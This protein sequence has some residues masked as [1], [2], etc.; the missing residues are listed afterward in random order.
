MLVVLHLNLNWYLLIK[1]KNYFCLKHKKCHF[2]FGAQII[3]VPNWGYVR[4]NKIVCLHRNLFRRSR[5]KYCTKVLQSA[6]IPRLSVISSEYQWRYGATGT[7]GR[8]YSGARYV[9]L[10][11]L[12][13]INQST[14]LFQVCHRKCRVLHRR[15]AVF[16]TRCRLATVAEVVEAAEEVDS[17]TRMPPI[18][19]PR[20][21]PHP[22]Q[23]LVKWVL[24]WCYCVA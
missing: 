7:A 17:V 24:A 15:R 20:N 1:E 19:L 21:L 3:A 16:R 4:K 9:M 22:D 10:V 18:P 12:R 8:L 2:K 5:G 6:V 13:R 11:S 14:S 23:W